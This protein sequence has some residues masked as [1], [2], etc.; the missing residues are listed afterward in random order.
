[1][2]I[3]KDL[4]DSFYLHIDNGGPR[5]SIYKNNQCDDC[6]LIRISDGYN[7]N[8]LNI[9]EFYQQITPDNLRKIGQMFLR[10]ADKIEKV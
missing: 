8:S 3:N 10:A 5:F 2:F 9:M 7:G 4:I 1:V 6:Y